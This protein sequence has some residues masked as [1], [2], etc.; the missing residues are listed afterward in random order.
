MA[1]AMA[2]GLL[3][4]TSAV[5]SLPTGFRDTVALSGLTHPTNFRFAADGRIFVA[6]KSGLIKVFQSLADTHPT[7][8]ADLRTQVD[9]YWDRGLLGLAL[10]PQFPTRPYVYA[11]YTYDAPLGA[12][13]PKWNDACPNPPGPTTDG[14]VVS[15]RLV[16]LTA[17]GNVSTGTPLILIS[18]WC[19]Q[20]PSH[21][22]GDLAFGADGALY[23]SGGEGASFT[24]ADYGQAKNPCGDPPSGVGGTQTA[25]TAQGGALR[26]QDLRT[27]ADPT[28]LDGAILRVD[29]ATGAGASGNPLASSPDANA[30]RIVAYG[31]RNPFRFTLRP[32][33]GELWI[34]DVGWS[35]WEE[36]DRLATP[37]SGPANFGWPCYEG[38]GVQSAYQALGLS[39]C[40]GLYSAPS[41]VTA[42]YYTYQHSAKVV[43]GESCPSGNSSL[44]GLAF[45]TGA[46]YPA[47][48]SNALFFSDYSRN[49][50]WVMPAGSNGLPA[51]AS[52]ATFVA[53]A[54]GPVDLETG[55]NGD[56]FYADLDGGAIHRIQYSAANR[57]PVAVA[58]ATPS[59]GAVPLT[60][61][62]DA[63][64]SS[65]PDGNPVTYAWDLN[66]DGA[67]T[68]STAAKPS[69]TYNTAGRRTVG[70]KVTD[71]AGASSTATVTVT[72]GTPPNAVIDTPVSTTTW[73]VGDAM[74][75]TGHAT[76]AI[77]GSLPASALT[78]AVILHHCA[79]D[80]VT[81]HTHSIQ[82]FT[83]V[84]SGSFPAPDHEYPS[85]LELQL[86]A[87]N[88]VG[89]TSTKSL[90][91][92]PKTVTLSFA[93][94]PSGL[95]LAVGS[96]TATTPFTRT[97]IVG[98]SNSVSAPSPQTL[99]TTSYAFSSWSDGRVASHNIIAPA[100][101]T[102]YTARYVSASP[103]ATL[104]GTTALGPT[105]DSNPA[106]TAE[107]L[108]VQATGTGALAFL[109]V[110]LNWGADTTRMTVGLYSDSAGNPGTLL[111]QATLALP[112]AGT[113]NRVAVPSVNVTA[114]QSYW[115]A[116]LAPL[117]SGTGR[118][119][120][121][122]WM[123]T[124][125][126]VRGSASKSLT[127][128]PA[129]WT[130][131]AAG[132]DGPASAYGSAAAP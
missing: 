12:S 74:A 94:Q 11:L 69:F 8:F 88:S 127:T 46:S 67:Y 43:S 106:G 38:A 6:E 51:P 81:C 111:S 65:D 92:D 117:N 91:L 37:T 17:S 105:P 103:G 125:T 104:V 49:C 27:T 122:D 1:F 68:D 73:K 100:T 14:C 48:Y 132:N 39:I 131:S 110:F 107:A 121:L 62:F 120:F 22:I 53:P 45:Y 72:A 96:S 113:W 18:D 57:P 87:K 36:I 20:F 19:Q 4:S 30:R 26:A 82:T 80:G 55:P 109:T 76:D 35:Q 86:T 33:T 28:G 29:P 7:V 115:I 10:D 9:D 21:S 13:A 24:Y 130:S 116:L 54:A 85:Y 34:G 56:L 99:G 124:G 32:G 5:A 50:I 16:R 102:T 84:A 129:T 66:A 42:P 71:S 70:L 123:G 3:G 31:F 98:S 90:R 52:R 112:T 15:G 44:S 77:D 2:A 89:I 114:G 83:G 93:S 41:S 25:P 63:T 64:G 101:A 108:R 78:W 95:A 40:Q 126:P 47:A 58:K 23:V 59:S 128:L 61:A 60:V 75:F 79:P 118:L 97:V 119:Q